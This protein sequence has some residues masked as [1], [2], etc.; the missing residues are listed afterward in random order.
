M[1]K[2]YF[3]PIIL[4]SSLLTLAVV[5]GG[6]IG[7][8]K[9][10]DR[11]RSGHVVFP[12]HNPNGLAPVPHRGVVTGSG[13][14]PLPTHRASKAVNYPDL[15][16]ALDAL[17]LYG[18]EAGKEIMQGIVGDLESGRLNIRYPGREDHRYVKPEI[19]AV[20]VD[21]CLDRYVLKAE[22]EEVLDFEAFKA[23]KEPLFVNMRTLAQF[24]QAKRSKLGA[25]AHAAS[26]AYAHVLA[27]QW[28]VAQSW[29]EDKLFFASQEKVFQALFAPDDLAWK[30][31]SG[32]DEA[33][34][35]TFRVL[36]QAYRQVQTFKLSMILS[37]SG[38]PSPL[39]S[40]I[41]NDRD[42]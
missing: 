8:S 9:K 36:F 17:V 39:L 38:M 21:V 6:A 29:R 10:K 28:M 40:S 18:G 27:G 35:R 24:A 22:E 16:E 34:G 5:F 7:C 4:L 31:G 42:L 37:Q 14:T 11:N 15:R 2:T 19:S 20:M 13:L 1:R 41:L 25:N 32:V 30:E 12:H 26:V 23:C 3:R 33:H